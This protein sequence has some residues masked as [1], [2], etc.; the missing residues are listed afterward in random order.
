MAPNEK[1]YPAHPCNSL[2]CPGF[3]LVQSCERCVWMKTDAH[4][5]LHKHNGSCCWFYSQSRGASNMVLSAL[6]IKKTVGFQW[7]SQKA[8]FAGGNRNQSL[9]TRL[10]CKS[11][12]AAYSADFNAGRTFRLKFFIYK[13]EVTHWSKL[14]CARE[15]WFCAMRTKRFSSNMIV[16]VILFCVCHF[17]F[18]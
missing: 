3:L 17:Y 6:Q 16:L 7:D 5:A 8:V 10:L 1:R 13:P 14:V 9:C 18:C 4:T 12:C 15:F 11:I 2:M